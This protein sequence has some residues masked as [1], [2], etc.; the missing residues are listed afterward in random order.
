MA[1]TEAIILKTKW[2]LSRP[3]ITCSIRTISVCFIILFRE[4]VVVYM[5]RTT[6]RFKHTLCIIVYSPLTSVVPNSPKTVGVNIENRSIRT[7]SSKIVLY[8]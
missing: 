2:N 1:N 7:P 6:K 8:Q 4:E 5:K 3:P